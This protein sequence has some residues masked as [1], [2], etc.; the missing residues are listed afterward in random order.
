M[1]VTLVYLAIVIWAAA[2]HEPW[3]DE[4]VPLSI[5]RH[6]QS[7][8]ELAAPLRFEGH[9]MLWYLV[10]W[11]GYRL[12]AETW[13]LKLASVA[14]AAGAI[15]LLNRS[16]LP[17]WLRWLFTFSFFPIYQ[18]S[19]V[20][21][22]YS[23][24][25]LLLFGFCGLYPHRRDHPLALALVLAALANTEAFGL[26]MAVAAVAML[27]AEKLAANSSANSL[28]RE[29][30][31]D[32]WMQGATAVYVA[33]LALAAWVAFPAAGHPLTGFRRLDL[34]TVA[35]GVGRAVVQPLGHATQFAVLP[36]PS[37]WAWGYFAYLTRRLPVLC[38]AASALIGIETLF[39]LVYGPGAPW[40]VGNV[41]LVVVAAMWLATASPTATGTR[42]ALPEPVRVWLGRLLLAGV[43]AAFA[44][45]VLLG[46]GHLSL[47]RQYDYSANRRL[48]A[49]LQE[50][51]LAGAVVMGEPDTP[52]WSLPYYADNRIYLPR[53]ATYRDWGMFAPPRRTQYD[54]ASLLQAARSV[55]DRPVVIT[56]GMELSVPG[57]YV[58]FR[59]T[60]FEETF[61]ITDETRADFQASTRLLAHLGPTITDE[62]YYV[63]VLR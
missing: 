55:R 32:P 37:L 42:L 6:A 34:W 35:G 46:I 40:H 63:Y 16:A 52:L 58:N 19:V 4:V 26:I 56:L 31:S 9:P 39:N 1:P 41:M 44:G 7:L 47:D 38:F 5:A 13:V 15:F 10:L 25:M 11:G 48:A 18:Y 8:A 22:G 24:E 12:V 2:R 14:S 51:S 17:W 33:G 27:V 28:W 36:A 61:L 45:Q 49:L 21:R 53:E 23:L 62:N 43:T 57:T 30:A 54:L 20:S 59:G 60:Q 50:P 29:V 3:R